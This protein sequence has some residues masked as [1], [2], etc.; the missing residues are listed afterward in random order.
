MGIFTKLLIILFF[1]YIGIGLYQL[2]LLINPLHGYEWKPNEPIIEP[3]WSHS[4]DFDIIC[5]MSESQKFKSFSLSDLLSGNS[6]ESYLLL[7]QKQ[8]KYN[9]SQSELKF[10]L[11]I[12]N[13][14]RGTNE[15][16]KFLPRNMWNNIHSNST[17]KS[18]YLHVLIRK[19]NVENVDN[20]T[21]NLFREGSALYGTVN[22]I[23]LDKIP[24]SFKHRYLLSDFGL[25]N[26]SESDKIKLQMPLDT[27]IT[28]WKP[29]V[30]VRLVTDF[31]VYP[32]NNVPTAIQS[33]TFISPSVISSK[34]KKGYTYKPHIHVDE[35]GL[36]SD[37]YIPLNRTVTS[38]PIK[39]SYAPMSPQR[40]F[41]MQTMEESI[42][43]QSGLGFSEKD[44]DDVR[45]LISDTSVYLLSITTIAAI[46]HLF[47]E[48]LALKS[49]V[50]F[51]N[52][53][54]SLA[55]LSSRAVVTD[56]FSQIIVFLYLIDSNT[57]LLVTIPSCIGIF[58]QIWKAK[59][60]TGFILKQKG[61]FISF[62]FSRWK[63]KSI[64][65]EKSELTDESKTTE[66][67]VTLDKD[68]K[69]KS[70][71]RKRGKKSEPLSIPKPIHNGDITSEA[72]EKVTL[73]ADETATKYIGTFLFPIVIGFI[74]KS[75]VYDKHKSWYSFGISSLCGF[76]YTFGFILMCPQLFINH[77]LKSVSHLPWNFLIYKFLNTFID[78]LFAFIIKM[79]TMHRLSVFRDDIVF[80]IYLYQRW[81]YRV[82]S[83]RPIEK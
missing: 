14:N 63:K 61:I 27:K 68:N 39:I 83:S 55:G 15:N 5:F 20:V 1:G 35:I 43:Q 76:V 44:L 36:T 60:A 28:Y 74:V 2:F 23:K 13:K 40:F 62:E 65:D 72:L 41:L 26:I 82:D 4:Q 11:N 16:T 47:F 54:K 24:K 10:D 64:E 81:I 56:L 46:L 77:K 49:D 75:L 71:L 32:T 9:E 38:L 51:W 50:Q 7:H 42:A 21:H 30:A 17:T 59:K 33:Q 45:R 78:D 31:T 8:L 67:E 3:F 37:K 69:E 52:Q 6:K 53:N 29:E 34:N 48:F 25:V 57:S 18:V 79:P 19:S 12:V 80:L 70:I 58:I 66:Q 73:E 22:L